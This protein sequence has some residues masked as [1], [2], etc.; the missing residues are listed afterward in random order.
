MSVTIK[1]NFKF[2]SLTLIPKSTLWLAI[3]QHPW[4]QDSLYHFHVYCLKGFL[5]IALCNQRTSD[6][7]S[8]NEE[9]KS[10]P[11]IIPKMPTVHRAMTEYIKQRTPSPHKIKRYPSI[12]NQFW[13]NPGIVKNPLLLSSDP[14]GYPF[15]LI[16]Q[17][18]C[19]LSF[20]S[21][22]LDPKQFLLNKLQELTS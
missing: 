11:P 14:S 19:N 22:I 8:I 3:T 20:Y 1:F 5:I 17:C 15:I 2:L 4:A 6:G 16:L 10:L 9:T 21:A 18:L 7:A 12:T 13:G